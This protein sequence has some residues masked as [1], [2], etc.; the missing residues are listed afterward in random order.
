MVVCINSL[1]FQGIGVLDVEVQVHISP[2]MPTFSIVGLPD[3]TITESRERVRAALASLGLIL[4]AKKI[5]VNLAPA[6]LIKEGSHFDLAI[7][8]GI[9]TYLNIIPKDH[10]QEYIVLGELALDGRIL[11]VSGI[12]P[13]AI[14][15]NARGKGMICAYENGREAAWSG[16][17]DIL[18]CHNIL[19]IINHFKGAQILTPAAIDALSDDNTDNINDN[20]DLKHIVGQEVAKRALEIAAAGGHNILMSGPP[21]SG[22]SMLAKSMPSILPEMSFEEILECSMVYSVAGLIRDGKLT[23]ERPFRAPHHSCSIAAMV[24]GGF[25]NRIKPG[26]ISL[27]HN[28]VLFLDELPEFPGATVDALRQPLEDGQVLIARSGVHVTYPA[29]FQLIAAMNPCKCG[30]LGDDT[31]GCNRAPKCGNDYLSRISGPIFD[32]FDIN[33]EVPIVEPWRKNLT[34][35]ESSSD[36]AR[37]IQRARKIQLERYDG[38]GIR[39][40]SE[41]YGQLL[42]DYTCYDSAGLDI[43]NKAGEHFK[44]SMRSHNKILKVARTIAD[45]DNNPN[46][47]YP[48]IAEAL[49]YNRPTQQFANFTQRLR[50][51]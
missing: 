33:I 3:K 18:A 7:A 35:K 19:S 48:H 2:G 31:R 43:L 14:G 34:S 39:T 49:E 41:L 17:T 25:S 1:T 26:E 20:I 23:T 8:C 29:K 4:P 40:N 47:M 30:Y 16:N 5:L 24:G 36:V 37:R 9:L 44:I 28:G 46:V 10:V 50:G 27:A 45:L 22:K 6:D 12:L 38:Y 21:G 13:A 51:A 15:A 11:P 42:T 32:R